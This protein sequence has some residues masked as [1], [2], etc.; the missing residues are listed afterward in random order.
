MEIEAR[1]RL[2]G[3]MA[4]GD[5][6]SEEMHAEVGGTAVAG[7]LDLADVL[8]LIDDRIDECVV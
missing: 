3:P 5:Q 1:G 7:V 2:L 6:A 8:G 4:A